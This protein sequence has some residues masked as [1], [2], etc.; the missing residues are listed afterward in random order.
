MIRIRH[1][2]EPYKELEL[3][4][5]NLQLAELREAILG[6]CNSDEPTMDLAADSQ[7][8][9]AP[10]QH[11][12]SRLHLQKTSELIIISAAAG[13][14][15]ISGKPELLRLFSENLPY[16]AHQTSSIPYHVHFDRIGREDHVSEASLGIVLG[17]KK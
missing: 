8:D 16:N 7:F 12:L 14:L 5:T 1:S 2:T 11:R 3:E 4:G 13:T 17:L 9:P 15:S 10:Y 6:F